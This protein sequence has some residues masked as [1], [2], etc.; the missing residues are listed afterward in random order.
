MPTC[1]RSAKMGNLRFD[2][3]FNAYV[4]SFYAMRMRMLMLMLMERVGVVICS[5]YQKQTAQLGHG[6]G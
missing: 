3:A 6:C 5:V 4:S 2:Y 1:E